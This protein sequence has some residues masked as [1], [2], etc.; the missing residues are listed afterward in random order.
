MSE[1]K[2]SHPA[3]ERIEDHLLSLTATTARIEGQL[4]YVPSTWQMLL[5]L[6]G[7]QA[8]LAGLL[9]GAFKLGLGH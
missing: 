2:R 4:R 7:S 6:F 5:G 1:R 9:F 8:T 3:L